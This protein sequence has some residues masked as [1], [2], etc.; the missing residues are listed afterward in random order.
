M[1]RCD[2]FTRH[3]RLSAEVDGFDWCQAALR[4]VPA[5]RLWVTRPRL[6][7]TR[8]HFEVTPASLHNMVAAARKWGQL[9]SSTARQHVTRH[10]VVPG[11]PVHHVGTSVMPRRRSNLVAASQPQP[12]AADGGLRA[13]PPATTGWKPHQQSVTPDAAP[14]VQVAVAEFQPTAKCCRPASP[15]R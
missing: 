13:A 6:K 4:A 5:E 3:G 12:P 8:C 2:I 7:T 14:A 1:A 10:V 11:L 15:P 9:T